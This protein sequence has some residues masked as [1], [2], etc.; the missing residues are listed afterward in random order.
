MGF[1]GSAEPPPSLHF[2]GWVAP[3]GAIMIRPKHVHSK[4]AFVVTLNQ[5][6][7]RRLRERRLELGLTQ[8]AVADRMCVTAARVTHIEK[9]MDDMKL[10]G[11]FRI[12]GILELDV[13]SLVQGIARRAESALE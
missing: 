8:K 13:T 9:G 12:A 11:L 7:G 3:K 1:W 10:S 2:W 4:D 5:E 6:I